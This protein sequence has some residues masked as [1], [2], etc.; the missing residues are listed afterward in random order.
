ML[1]I[2]NLSISA[3]DSND[4]IEYYVDIL[5]NLFQECQHNTLLS[6]CNNDTLY[7]IFEEDSVVNLQIASCVENPKIK[8]GEPSE[9]FQFHALC[10]PRLEY[11]GSIVFPVDKVTKENDDYIVNQKSLYI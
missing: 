5:D 6:S 8:N 3:K 1:C 10:P 2:L 7:F 11:D 4:Y 9:S